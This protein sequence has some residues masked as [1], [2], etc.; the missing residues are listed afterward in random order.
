[1][2]LGCQLSVDDGPSLLQ[3]RKLICWPSM[4]QGVESFDVMY[5]HLVSRI[6]VLVAVDII[7]G[8]QSASL[9]VAELSSQSRSE[10]HPASS[11]QSA[12]G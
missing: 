9:V 2:G 4:V 11:P 10:C 12:T 5:D 3:V 7:G 6:H 8:I 1:M